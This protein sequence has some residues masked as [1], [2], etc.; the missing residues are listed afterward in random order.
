MERSVRVW[1]WRRRR[2]GRGKGCPA[3]SRAAA[4]AGGSP[5]EQE[6]RAESGGGSS[7]WGR[8]RRTL[9]SHRELRAAAAGRHTLARRAR[10]SVGAAGCAG[11]RRRLE[12]LQGA[13]LRSKLLWQWVAN[14]RRRRAESEPGR[15][16]VCGSPFSCRLVAFLGRPLEMSEESEVLR[17]RGGAPRR[18]GIPEPLP[19]SWSWGGDRDAGEERALLCKP[20]R[21]VWLFV[22]FFRRSPRRSQAVAAAG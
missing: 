15:C 8:R 17:F 10:L 12:P 21:K 1:R 20:H 19:A 6:V 11:L 14:C 3:G 9:H 18:V 22:S 7:G 2:R 13:P 16:A 5:R 4:A